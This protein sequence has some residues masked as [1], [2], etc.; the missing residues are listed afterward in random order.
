MVLEDSI[1][2]SRKPTGT[3]F[4]YVSKI[5]DIVNKEKI[6]SRQQMN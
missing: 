6:A 1:C 4:T 5:K 2:G 3:D